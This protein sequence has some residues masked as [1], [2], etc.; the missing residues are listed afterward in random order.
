M[1]DV[2]EVPA[3]M[4]I[5]YLANYLKNNVPAVRPPQWALFVKTGHFKSRLP[6][7]PDWWYVRTASI[8]RKL[9]LSDGPVGVGTLRTVYG[10]L[11]RRGSAPPHF[12]KASGAI[13]RHIL[14]QLEAAGLVARVGGK[15]RVLTPN[16]T[17]LLARIANEVFKEAVKLIPELAKY[18]PG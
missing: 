11:K 12:R 9:Y 7:D 4:F 16:G 18:A 2:R 6:E 10:G 13:I 17:S 14:Q 15:G 5:K 1:V 8:L 3:D